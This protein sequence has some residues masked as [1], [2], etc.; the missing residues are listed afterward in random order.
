MIIV[1]PISVARLVSLN[2]NAKV[3]EW[4][5]IFGITC[6]FLSGMSIHPSTGYA[7]CCRLCEYDHLF[8]DTT[9]TI[10]RA[11]VSHVVRARETAFR[12]KSFS[13]IFWLRW[14]KSVG[15]AGQDLDHHGARATLRR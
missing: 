5:W 4:A 7:D 14:T 9:C 10:A 6:L 12:S 8:R 13:T 15:E 3:P 1:L 11:L 2:E